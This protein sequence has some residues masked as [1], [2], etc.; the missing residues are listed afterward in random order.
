MKSTNVDILLRN[1]RLFARARD[2]KF[3]EA[4]RLVDEI[5]GAYGENGSELLD[6]TDLKDRMAALV[7]CLY[8]ARYYARL[9]AGGNNAEPPPDIGY[10]EQAYIDHVETMYSYSR[11]INR[12]LRHELLVDSFV[13]HHP[14][15]SGDLRAYLAEIRKSDVNL[16][17]LNL[18]SLRERM[19]VYGRFMDHPPAATSP[20]SG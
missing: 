10:D 20:A 17:Y 16:L 4:G 15:V 12:F 13:H 7:E 14:D 6:P 1:R 3:A 8:H 19:R 18:R 2:E 11:S 9:S 5:L